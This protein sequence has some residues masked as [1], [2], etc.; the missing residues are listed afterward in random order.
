MTTKNRM[1]QLPDDLQEFIFKEVHISHTKGV[2]RQLN[3]IIQAELSYLKYIYVMQRVAGSVSQ[4]DVDNN[5]HMVS[6][7]RWLTHDKG[8]KNYPY[9]G[10]NNTI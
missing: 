1:T 4:A 5:V 6:I 3:K 8:P 9:C 10:L 7:H 2:T